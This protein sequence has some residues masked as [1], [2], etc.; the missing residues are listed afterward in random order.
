MFKQV[1]GYIAGQVAVAPPKDVKVFKLADAEAGVAGR[2][3]YYNAGRITKCTAAT[4]T[5]AVI[6]IESVDADA[7]G[8]TARG[9]Y[10]TPGMVFKVRPSTANEGSVG[11]SDDKHANFLEGIAVAR[12][13][14]NGDYVDWATDPASGVISVLKLALDDSGDSWL[15]VAFNKCFLAA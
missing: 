1:Q 8:A 6:L 13:S 15:W 10:I 5:P 14:A 11:D 12:F 2:V 9:Y 7:G 3:Y 4:G